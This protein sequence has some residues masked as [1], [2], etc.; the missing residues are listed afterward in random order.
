ML[1]GILVIP[2]FGAILVVISALA[3]W[4]LLPRNGQ[5]H[6]L[7]TTASIEAYLPA[8]IIGGFALGIVL[9]LSLV[10]G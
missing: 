8:V 4:Y 6:W 2:L 3:F 9:V 1:G 5:P 7:A 10:T